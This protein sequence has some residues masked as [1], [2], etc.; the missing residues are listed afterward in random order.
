MRGIFALAA[1]LV[2]L[3]PLTLK[4]QIAAD[5]V[6]TEGDAIGDS[7]AV[8]LNSPFV[9]GLGQVGFNVLLEDKSFAIWFD[10]AVVFNSSSV[11]SPDL[12]Q[13][14]E[15]TMGFGN[16]GQ[17]AYSPTFDF[18]DSLRDQNGIVLVE[19]TQAPGFAA[20]VNTTFHNAPTMTD[21]GTTYWLSGFNDGMGGTASV[22]RILYRRDPAGN[23][24]VVIRSGDSI[25]GDTVDMSGFGS[26]YQFSRDNT[27]SIIEVDADTGSGADDGRVLVNLTVVAAEGSP[28]MDASA[29]PENDSWDNFRRFTINNAGNYVFSGDTSGAAI[30]RD[31]FIAYNGV[32]RLREGD[33]I[34]QGNLAGFVKGVTLNEGNSLAFVWDLDDGEDQLESLFFASDASDLTNL[35][36]VASVE[37]ELDVD[38]DGVADWVISDFAAGSV[39]GASIALTEDGLIYVAVDL[40]SVD[41]SDFRRAIVAVSASASDFLLGDVNRDNT[42]DFDDIAPFITLLA[43][44]GFQV[45]ADINQ[46]QSVDFDDI[47]PFIGLLAG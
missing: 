33:A 35:A 20:G 44:D 19:D 46:D 47:A 27:N 40:Q 26:D 45:E 16:A 8:L 3:S 12:N 2:A 38:G 30:T 7:T 41:G 10:G 43:T 15:S 21:D 1:L 36:V 11:I 24:D 42:V 17:F 9:N 28:V 25:S 6:L 5:L 13:T 39:T 29:T 14:V 37:D 31:E 23:I 34:A 4:G 18:E 22:G 32:I